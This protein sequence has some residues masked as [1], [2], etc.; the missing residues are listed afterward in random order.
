MCWRMV[1]LMGK[2][3]GKECISRQNSSSER[4]GATD[5]EQKDINYMWVRP[6]LTAQF[7]VTPQKVHYFVFNG[8]QWH[9]CARTWTHMRMRTCVHDVYATISRSSQHGFRGVVSIHGAE[10]AQL[11]IV[12]HDGPYICAQRQ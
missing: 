1:R 8:H 2:K 10:Q 5:Q 9:A 4:V 6:S 3:L 11:F 7:Y 12:H